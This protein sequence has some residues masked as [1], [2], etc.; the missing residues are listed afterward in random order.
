VAKSGFSKYLLDFVVVFCEKTR[1]GGRNIVDIV[2][3]VRYYET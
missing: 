2:I 3:K 1:W